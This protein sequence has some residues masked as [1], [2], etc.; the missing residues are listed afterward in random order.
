MATTTEPTR[1]SQSVG[2]ER[3]M[4]RKVF[5]LVMTLL[6]AFIL[7]QGFVFLRDTKG[8]QWVNALIAMVWGV[9]GMLILFYIASQWVEQLSPQWQ[10]RATPWVFVGPA[11]ALLLWY[12]V[13]PVIRTLIFSF[14]DAKSQNFVGL[15]NYAYAFTNS[16]MR[17]A[18]GNNVLWLLFGTGLS[19][20]MG[21]LI[22]VLLDR[23]NAKY[24][25][26]V[27]SLIFL[28]M[29]ISFVGAGVIWKFMYDFRPAGAEQIGFMNA[30]VTGLGGQPQP[31]LQIR[32]VNTF[33][34]ILILVWLQTGYCM[35]IQSAA[36]KGVPADLLEAGRID[37]ANE[38]QIF[39]QILIPTIRGTIITVATTVLILT[40]K[41]FDIVFTMTGG[42]FGTEVIAN[43]FY[44]QMFRS[45]QTGRGAAIAMV[46]LIATIPIIY[47]NLRQA[48]MRQ[49]GF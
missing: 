43:Q 47:Y 15:D 17:E 48:R 49:E 30:I 46:L 27:K 3:T 20:I 6:A 13:I 9:G 24:E 11:V 31:F 7:W 19:V 32:V 2:P 41:V 42:N 25:I 12:L 18:F 4:G 35:V 29:A 14:M 5:L 23:T 22:A 16:A 10:K 45:F 34:L 33:F 1:P 21:L 26:L 8:P 36:I 40:L 28:P 38:A 37:G 44:A 39:F